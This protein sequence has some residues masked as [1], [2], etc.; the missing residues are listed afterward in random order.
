MA[1]VSQSA[2]LCRAVIDWAGPNGVGFSHIIGIGG[3]HD[4]GF[5]PALDW[6]SRDPGT[7][8]ILLEIRQLKDR[9][10]FISAA[11]AAARLR[12]V[13]AMHAGVRLLDPAGRPERVFEAALR[14][15]GVLS[16]GGLDDLLAAAET[17]SRARP[18]RG[19]TLA[20]VTNAIGA[21]RLAADAALRR[22]LPLASGDRALVNVGVAGADRMAAEA[23][24]LAEDREVGGM[25]VV[26]APSGAGDERRHRRAAEC[27][28]AH[29]RAAAG[30][31]HGGKLRRACTVARWRRPGWRCSPRRTRRC[32]GS[33]TWCRTAATAPPPANCPPA[34]C[35]RWR[36]T[37]RWCADCSTACDGPAGWRCGRT[38]RWRCSPP[39]AFR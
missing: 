9:R 6:L 18:A 35:C 15:A 8:A 23:E 7:G 38:R 10:R 33:S 21:G 22:G 11:K 13:V 14:R 30:L 20:I 19:E 4:L 34:L 29:P 3:N 27:G 39:T 36:P 37:A 5:G 26:H 12:P 31:R 17:L 24:R 28:A 25:L 1:L 32:R 16:V 2:A